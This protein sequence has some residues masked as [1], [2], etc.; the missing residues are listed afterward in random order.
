MSGDSRDS[1][2]RIYRHGPAW[3]FGFWGLYHGAG[4]AVHGAWERSALGKRFKEWRGARFLG[5]AV[6]DVFVAYGWLLFFY[7]LPEVSRYTRVLFL[8]KE[9]P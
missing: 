1:R 8:G 2:I 4:L 7:S 9:S 5:T 6:T 3:H